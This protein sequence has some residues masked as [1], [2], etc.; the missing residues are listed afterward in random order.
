MLLRLY[1]I[2]SFKLEMSGIYDGTVP[3]S[4]HFTQDGMA[5]GVDEAK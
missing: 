5:S 3:G 4:L 2:I 1:L